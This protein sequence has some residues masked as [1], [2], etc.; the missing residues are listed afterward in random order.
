[1][2]PVLSKELVRSVLAQWT[3][4]PVE[5]IVKGAD[6]YVSLENLQE[7][8]NSVIFGQEEAI[9]A[10]VDAL[11]RR[12]VLRKEGAVARPIAT[13]MFIGP[14]GTGKT[15]LAKQIAIHFF[16]DQRRLIKIN[17]NDFREPHTASRLV[18][19]P[20]GY[21]GY[22][23]GGQLISAISKE[24]F[25][26]VLFDEIEK[27]HPE[28]VVNILLQMMGEGV[29]T[30]MSTGTIVDCSSV[31]ILMTSNLGNTG[32]GQRNIGFSQIESSN[33]ER[34]YRQRV[35]DAVWDF[36]PP[37]FIGRIDDIIIFNHLGEEALMRIFDREVHSLEEQLSANGSVRI[38]ISELARKI[39]SQEARDEQLGARTVQKVFSER[40]EKPC[41]EL[42]LSGYLERDKPLLITVDLDAEGRFVYEVCNM[43]DEEK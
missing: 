5:H 31:M 3:G 17:M 18:G 4:I 35:I 14:S 39:F 6:S 33:D 16:G 1:M 43:S 23:Q 7:K 8:L 28:V 15:E 24:P 42:K 37:E 36:F 41:S 2:R 9:R 29:L 20:P 21:V 30:D 34:H 22:N 26:V 32:V 13:L 12:A 19:A 40:I 10:V 25:S 11:K 27:A 38:K